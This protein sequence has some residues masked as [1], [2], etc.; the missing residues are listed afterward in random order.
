[1]ASLSPLLRHG[2]VSALPEVGLVVKAG[3]QGGLEALLGWIEEENRRIK[4][5]QPLSPLVAASL[6]TAASAAAAGAAG[7]KGGSISEAD[8]ARGVLQSWRP[9]RVVRWGVGPITAS[10]VTHAQLT[11]SMLIAFGTPLLDSTQQA[12]EEAGLPLRIQSV[13]YRL[14][15]DLSLISDFH[16]GPKFEFVQTARAHITQ[17]GSYVLKKRK[18]GL[19]TV[20]G[21]EVKQ[22]SPS[23]QH[24]FALV[25]DMRA[26]YE[27]FSSNLAAR[28]LAACVQSILFFAFISFF[29]LGRDGAIIFDTSFD[30]F[31]EGDV[32]VAFEEREKAPPP[33]LSGHHYMSDPQ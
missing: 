23:T 30:D 9:L 33:F 10:D 24:A 25:A 14:F 2:G 21:L 29:S 22:G 8:A 18:G 16:F 32:L 6:K 26:L 4:E 7:G 3:D 19:Q 1:M 27:Q 13:V 17:V 28:G 31:R 15:E 11:K 20:I 12:I 5:S